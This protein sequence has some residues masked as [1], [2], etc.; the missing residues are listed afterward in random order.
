LPAERVPAVQVVGGAG[1]IQIR[2]SRPAL[3]TAITNA[4]VG[5]TGRELTMITN[6]S[7]N[8][9]AL[10]APLGGQ[11]LEYSGTVRALAPGTYTVRVWESFSVARPDLLE[12]TTVTVSLAG[13]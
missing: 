8:P 10:C 13:A 6:V 7:P 5:V 9:A 12:T 4:R 3:C 1:L 2:V 11:L